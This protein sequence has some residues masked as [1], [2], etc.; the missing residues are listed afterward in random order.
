MIL[1]FL[2]LL[3]FTSMSGAQLPIKVHLQTQE[4]APYQYLEGEELKGI[5]VEAVRCSFKKLNIELELTVVPWSRA[6]LNTREGKVDGFFAASQNS[7]RDQYA[8]LS[9]LALDQKWVWFELKDSKGP[10]TPEQWKN[11]S[12]GAMKGSNMLQTLKADDFNVALEARSTDDLFRALQSRR[13]VRILVSQL[14]AKE[15]ADKGKV[16]LSHFK[17]TVYRNQ[18]LGV[19]FAASFLQKYPRFL[20]SFNNHFEACAEI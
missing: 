16:D 1:K 6:Q 10:S 15:L 17:E 11:L 5:A 3:I 18:P 13:V 9:K 8:T 7:S 14:V 19:Y 20:S 12:H 2:G 4:W